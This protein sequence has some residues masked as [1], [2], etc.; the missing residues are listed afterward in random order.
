MAS[1]LLIQCPDGSSKTIP[2]TGTRLAVGR[3]STAEL[4]F[5]EDAG[6]SRQHFAFESQGEDWTIQDLGSK[7]GTFVNNI[8]LK[9]RLVLRPGDRIT[10]GHLSIVYAPGGEAPSPGVVVFEGDS[11]SPTTS[12]VVTSLAGA[13]SS[14]TMASERGGAKASAPMQALIRAGQELS[15]NRP[16]AELFPVILDL[17]IQAVNAQRGVLLLQE[18]DG[19]VPKAHQGDGFRISTAVRDRVMVENSSVLVRDAQLDDAFKGRMSIVEHKVHTMM[20]VPLQTKDQTIGLIYVDSPFILREFTKDDLSLLTVMAN[21]AAIR[22]ENARLAEVEVA[23]RMFQRELSQAAEIQRRMLPDEAPKVANADLAGY[24]A[25]CRT[26]GGDYYDFFDYGDGRVAMALGDVSGKGMPASLMMM[27]LHARVQVLAEDPGNLSEF[28]TRLNKAT[29]AN[30]PSN[31]FITFF[32]CVLTAGTGDVRYA[33]AGHNPP[34]VVRASGHTELLEGAGPVL[35]IMPVATYSEQ[36]AHLDPGDMLV[37]YSDGV[38]EAN[39]AEFEEYGEARFIDVLR[40]YRHE[41]AAV[42]VQAVTQSVAAFTAGAAQ[43]DDI[44]LMVAQRLA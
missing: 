8:P 26:V 37:L 20:A 36:R 25:A 39:N 34:I 22:I 9:A 2:L 44:T 23:E 30:C 16:L 14:Q 19:L 43:A 31:R 17:A 21:V 5:P 6:L 29:C 1:E 33:N 38:T 10:A 24:N 3:S 12:T 32:F 13:L 7:N 27:A 40:Q 4:C 28:M 11:S 18:R 15:E 42:I 41:P 35:G